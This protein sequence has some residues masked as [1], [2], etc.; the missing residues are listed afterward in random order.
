MVKANHALSNPALVVIFCSL[1]A[2]GSGLLVKT[3]FVITNYVY[4]SVAAPPYLKVWIRH[5][6]YIL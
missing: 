5:C 4:N 6:N 1:L 3:T 2:S